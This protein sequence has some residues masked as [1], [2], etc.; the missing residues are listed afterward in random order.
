MWVSKLQSITSLQN[1]VN[2]I[3]L[4]VEL[5]VPLSVTSAAASTGGFSMWLVGN[6][7][8]DRG[9]G[10]S[11]GYTD[12]ISRHEDVGVELGA[13]VFGLRF[14]FDFGG[15]GSGRRD[16][17]GSLGSHGGNWSSRGGCG[18]R[19][20]S[21]RS[22]SRSGGRSDQRDGISRV[23]DLLILELQGLRIGGKGI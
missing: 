21:R 4:V 6:I 11:V 22:G 16:F 20:G 1:L 8:R 12:G 18:S 13:G 14:D 15:G 10:L 5:V 19:C 2:R 17:G 3:G 23:E 9:R 7:G